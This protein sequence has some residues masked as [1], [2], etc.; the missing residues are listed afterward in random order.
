MLDTNKNFVKIMLKIGLPIAIQCV[1][2][3]CLNMVDQVIVSELGEVALASVGIANRITTIV[4]FVLGALATGMSIFV[5]QYVGNKDFKN[6]GRMTGVG[7]ISSGVV[8]TVIMAV[9]LFFPRQVL[10]IFTNDDNVV[11]TAFS[12]FRIVIFSFIPLVF[13]IVYSA[14]LRSSMKAKIPMVASISATIINIIIDYVLV[15]GKCGFN[16]MGVEGA[17]L[18]TVIARCVELLIILA[19][20]YSQKV[21]TGISLLERLKVDT[22]LWKKFFVTALPIVVSEM[23]WVLG[24]TTYN[25]IYSRIGTVEYAAM[26]VMYPMQSVIIGLLTGISGATVV[27]LGNMIGAGNEDKLLSCAKRVL[28]FGCIISVVA[29]ALVI[30]S[31]NVYV[32]IY[33][34]SPETVKISKKILRVFGCIIWIKIT[35]MIIGNGVLSSGGDSRFILVMDSISTWVIGIPLGMISA[36]ILHMPIEQVYLLICFEEFIRMF[37]GLHRIKSKKWIHNLV[38]QED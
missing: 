4:N 31:T 16:K 22:E 5:A 15:F 27:V 28:I 29:G 3:N 7:L 23:L 36:F 6:A 32:S 19:C 1:I 17:A 18:G 24:D 9:C 13:S 8:V 38:K 2:V 33:N 26:S 14:Y 21:F 34:V 25:A 12:F 11:D 35:N 30:L 10:S 20:I 37:V